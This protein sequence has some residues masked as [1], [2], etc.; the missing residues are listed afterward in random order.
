[1]HTW[2]YQGVVVELVVGVELLVLPA[3]HQHQNPPLLI[4]SQNQRMWDEIRRFFNNT[5][6]SSQSEVLIMLLLYSIHLTTM[7]VE[8]N[9]SICISVKKRRQW[10]PFDDVFGWIHHLSLRICLKSELF[11]MQLPGNG[12]LIDFYLY[13]YFMTLYCAFSLPQRTIPFPV[14]WHTTHSIAVQAA[15]AVSVSQ[16][17]AVPSSGAI[18][19]SDP[20]KRKHEAPSSSSSSSSV[21]SDSSTVLGTAASASEAEGTDSVHLQFDLMRLTCETTLYCTVLYYST[22]YCSILHYTALYCT[23]LCTV[24]YY[25]APYYTIMHC[26][27]LHFTIL[28]YTV[29]HFTILLITSPCALQHPHIPTHIFTNHTAPVQSVRADPLG[30][31]GSSSLSVP[32]SNFF[33]HDLPAAGSRNTLYVKMCP[34]ADNCVFGDRCRWEAEGSCSVVLSSADVETTLA[35]CV[36]IHTSLHFINASLSLSLSFFL[37][38]SLSLS[39][40]FLCL[41]LSFF[42]LSLS[43]SFFSV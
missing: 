11:C 9:P 13:F 14:H 40:F 39:L 42:S 33:I 8:W 22:L 17:R 35:R 43:L 3:R 1:M 16:P 25:T 5:Q 4:V 6:L 15:A 12:I 21:V 23:A 34:F 41:S 36:L 2:R 18:P 37:F 30:D 32:V 31:R 38:F 27:I 20:R 7:K 29:L 26:T 10:K 24:L 19:V 28:Y